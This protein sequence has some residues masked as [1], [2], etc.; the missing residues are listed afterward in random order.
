MFNKKIIYT[1][2]YCGAEFEFLPGRSRHQDIQDILKSYE[3]ECTQKKL[4]KEMLRPLK[5][6]KP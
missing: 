3:I 1:C 2:Q 4:M 6:K 5:G